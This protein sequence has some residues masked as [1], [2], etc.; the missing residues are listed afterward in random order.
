MISFNLMIVLINKGCIL[1]CAKY[2]TSITINF[3]DESIW[4]LEWATAVLSLISDVMTLI[5]HHYVSIVE[6]D[7]RKPLRDQC[8]FHTPSAIVVMCILTATRSSVLFL[9]QLIVPDMHYMNP[10]F[11]KSIF[12]NVVWCLAFFEMTKYYIQH[13]RVRNPSTDV[14]VAFNTSSGVPYLYGL[15]PGTPFTNIDFQHGQEITRPVKCGMQSFIH[16][17]TS[18]TLYVPL[19][20]GMDK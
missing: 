5:W 10:F 13:M 20:L 3:V 12:T 1:V 7:D 4:N 8:T 16:S 15:E 9:S 14:Y 6:N 2:H 11:D 19:N 18:T 17:Q